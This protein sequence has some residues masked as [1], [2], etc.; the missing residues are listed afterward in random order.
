MTSKQGRGGKKPQP[1]RSPQPRSKQ[2]GAFQTE[3]A[4]ESSEEE[5]EWSERLQLQQQQLSPSQTSGSLTQPYRDGDVQREA[6]SSADQRARNKRDTPL[7]SI[8]RS[9]EATQRAASPATSVRLPSSENFSSD[10]VMSSPVAQDRALL[11]LR[12][13]CALLAD[14]TQD[15][16][17]HMLANAADEFATADAAA[18]PELPHLARKVTLQDANAD[19]YSAEESASAESSDQEPV[20]SN[21]TL[22]NVL[23]NSKSFNSSRIP[24]YKGFADP[25]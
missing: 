14:T 13:M 11:L 10:P 1:E 5:V 2:S 20:L 8:L 24:M 15:E 9:E 18:T 4:E 22:V 3:I 6:L 12:R 19:I 17:F 7:R 25:R 16:R 21:R 23:T